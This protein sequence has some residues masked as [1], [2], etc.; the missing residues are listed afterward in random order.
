MDDYTPT[1]S[2]FLVVR[3]KMTF[4]VN[5]L[6]ENVLYL[7]VRIIVLLKQTISIQFICLLLKTN[8]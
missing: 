6:C 3:L 4:Y 8:W 1:H 5:V 7:G 2:E